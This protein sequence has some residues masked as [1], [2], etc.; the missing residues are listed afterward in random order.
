MSLGSA[1]DIVSY[2]SPRDSSTHYGVVIGTPDATHNLVARNLGVK[3]GCQLYWEAEESVTAVTVLS[4]TDA[5]H[6]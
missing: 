5:L 1:G 2:T 3:S 6:G 4:G